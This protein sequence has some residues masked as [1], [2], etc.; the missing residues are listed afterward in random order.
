MNQCVLVSLSVWM[1]LSYCVVSAFD[2]HSLLLTTHCSSHVQRHWTRDVGRYRVSLY[3]VQVVHWSLVLPFPI[4]LAFCL[5]RAQTQRVS[6]NV[7]CVQHRMHY[8]HTVFALKKK[9]EVH[10]SG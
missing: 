1:V 2:I 5:P 4:G 6:I 8:L 3:H 7:L 10:A 9:S